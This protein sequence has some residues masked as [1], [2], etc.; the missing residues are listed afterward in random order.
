M[1]DITKIGYAGKVLRVDLTGLKIWTEDL[2]MPT[3]KKWV[4]GVGLGAKYLYQE[5]P[6]GVEWSDPKNRLIWTTGPLAGT[7]V[8]GAAT[9]NIM[10]KGPMTNTA[11]SSQANGYM[12]AYMKFCGFDGIV[13]QG[14]APHLVYLLLRDGSVEI[15]DARHLSGKTVAEME[16]LL[17]SELGVSK[18]GASIFGIGPAGEHLVRHACIVGDGGHSASH[19]GIG[20]VMGSKNLKAVV[21]YKSK[22]NFGVYDPD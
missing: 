14:K 10:A 1:T 3:V 5:V 12:G 19:N 13:F 8:A 11:G 4:G 2:D 9:I 17:K 15:K 18:Y 22:Q 20:A 6:P 21:A 16:K 7:G